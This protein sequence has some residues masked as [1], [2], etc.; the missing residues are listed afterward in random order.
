MT[1][2]CL[3]C[4][5]LHVWKLEHKNQRGHNQYQPWR[6]APTL[7]AAEWQI[8]SPG[9]WQS[10]DKSLN[11]KGTV[12]YHFELTPKNTQKIMQGGAGR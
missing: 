9:E 8:Y 6:G 4:V 3:S 12:A 1:F 5:Y 10:N 11:I 7:W 2:P